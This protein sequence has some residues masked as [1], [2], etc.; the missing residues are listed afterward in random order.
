MQYKSVRELT[1]QTVSLLL[2]VSSRLLHSNSLHF[3]NQ[4]VLIQYE[5]DRADWWRHHLFLL[6]DNKEQFSIGRLKRSNSVEGGAIF[7]QHDYFREGCISGVDA[8]SLVR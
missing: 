2:P 3:Q 1:R 4:L 7:V 8:N 5:A 6:S